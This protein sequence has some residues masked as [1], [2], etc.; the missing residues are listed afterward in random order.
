MSK[1]KFSWEEEY[2]KFAES[3]FEQGFDYVLLGHLHIPQIRKSAGKTYVNCG[4]WIQSFSYACYDQ[5]SLILNRW[6]K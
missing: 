1:K 5:K 3:K 2:F 4:D 6:D